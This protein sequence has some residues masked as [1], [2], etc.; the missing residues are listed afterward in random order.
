MRPLARAARLPG[1][2]TDLRRASLLLALSDLSRRQKRLLTLQA[3]A[4]GTYYMDQGLKPW[5]PAVQMDS[6]GRKRLLRCDERAPGIQV[7]MIPNTIQELL[8]ALVG[9]GRLPAFKGMPT[10]IVKLLF[11]EN[12]M[13]LADEMFLPTFDIL[14]KG[15][16]CL[17]FSRVG[18]GDKR[19]FESIYMD[20]VWC[21]PIL[22][23]QA[24]D[25]I[26]GEIAEEL[27]KRGVPRDAPGPGE[28]LYVPPDA[29]SNDLIFLRYEP[30]WVDEDKNEVWRR[31][32][33]FLPNVTVEYNKKK[34]SNE[35]DK[36][37]PWEF[38]FPPDPHDWGVVPADWEAAA[39]AV[40]GEID[41][42]S[43]VTP[44]LV[45]MAIAT[46]Y[47][48]SMRND[49][50]K[51]IAWPQLNLIDVEDAS[52]PFYDFMMSM[53]FG[54]GYPT[55]DSGSGTVQ[56]Y[57]SVGGQKGT[58]TTVEPEG[59]GLDQAKKQVDDLSKHTEKHTAMV[60]QDPEDKAGVVSGTALEK[61]LEPKIARVKSYRKRLGRLMRRIGAK[62]GVVN[63]IVVPADVVTQW[64]RVVSS[65]PDDMAKLAEA[66]AKANGGR[67]IMSHKTS[68]ILFANLCEIPDPEVEWSVIE[69]EQ[70]ATEDR[71][72][73]DA[74][75]GNANPPP[76]KPKNGGQGVDHGAVDK[77]ADAGANAEE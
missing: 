10:K 66:M 18:R 32:R 46:D 11:D 4:R 43:V 63:G 35:A 29:A 69:A 49:S 1:M 22:A 30:T 53:G 27:D 33:E 42:P 68:A 20:T 65:T 34:I 76:N 21:T 75:D 12:Q 61:R 67:Q 45:S 54:G 13:N 16:Q 72:F 74:A 73:A 55:Q 77:S 47:I 2:T 41:G 56:Q 70:K 28:F 71:L 38:R 64:P 52:L 6:L 50:I 59:T 36:K 60:R 15:S 14:V 7:G 5:V 8:D 62:L 25:D 39:G 9:E 37:S 26:A 57:R 3:L 31:R 23:G 40:P 48:E 17:G 51:A 24:S 19:R 58:V 44:E